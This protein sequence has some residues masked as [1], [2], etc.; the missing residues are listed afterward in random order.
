[1][2]R[3]PT[4]VLVPTPKTRL[5]ARQIRRYSAVRRRI[6]INN[7]APA[8]LRDGAAIA[9][10]PASSTELVSDDFPT[11]ISGMMPELANPVSGASNQER[12]GPSR[13]ELEKPLTGTLL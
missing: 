13:E 7:S 8:V 3:N 1:M 5:A 10:R 9:P 4:G 12:K 6:S 2:A 11:F